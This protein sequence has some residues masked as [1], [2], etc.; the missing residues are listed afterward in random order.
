MITKTEVLRA[1]ASAE[2]ICGGNPL[3]AAL[4]AIPMGELHVL[5]EAAKCARYKCIGGNI[6]EPPSNSE[7]VLNDD[8]TKAMDDDASPPDEDDTL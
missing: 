2:T 3:S 7:A 4:V 6:G 5:V 8:E 1:V